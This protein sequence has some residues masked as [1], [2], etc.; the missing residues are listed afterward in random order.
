MLLLN[1]CQFIF[2]CDFIAVLRR[3]RSSFIHRFFHDTFSF[4]RLE[5]K[6]LNQFGKVN[7][8]AACMQQLNRNNDE[9]KVDSSLKL[10]RFLSFDILDSWLWLLNWRRFS[11]AVHF[12][13]GINQRLLELVRCF[14][15]YDKA[16]DIIINRLYDLSSFFLLE[17]VSMS[18]QH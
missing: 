7:L 15:V 4:V 10:T 1:T 2:Q 5:E 17:D 12:R 9:F 18:H 11:K 14:Y 16:E 8:I 6:C 3:I 13:V